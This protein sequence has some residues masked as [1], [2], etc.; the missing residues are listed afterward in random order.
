MSP[1]FLFSILTVTTSAQATMY[2]SLCYCNNFLSGLP[3]A[4]LLK[5]V[6]HS[7]TVILYM[8]VCV[9][10]YGQIFTEKCINHEYS[11]QQIFTP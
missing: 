10:V 7:D 9:C 5:Y 8:C 11:A 3:S 1:I 6:L 2:F 4:L